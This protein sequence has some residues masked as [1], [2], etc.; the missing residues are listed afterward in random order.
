MI[1]TKER[2]LYSFIPKSETYI[3]CVKS[4]NYKRNCNTSIKIKGTFQCKNVAEVFDN[5]SQI[6]NYY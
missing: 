2:Y 3:V 6:F 4:V 1:R 5:N